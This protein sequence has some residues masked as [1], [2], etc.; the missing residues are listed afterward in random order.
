MVL[1]VGKEDP[2]GRC[3][4]MNGQVRAETPPGRW[5]ARSGVVAPLAEGCIPRPETGF[6]AAR[7]LARGVTVV[8]TQPTQP[9]EAAREPLG[10]TGKTQLA[11]AL[12]RT[13]WRSGEVD[14]LAWVPAGSRDAVMTG[15]GRALAAVGAPGAGAGLETAAAGFLAWAAQTS[16]PWLVVLD[17]LADPGDLDGLW[18]LGPAGM[19]LATTRLPAGAMAGP[20]RQILEV[21]PF[22]P[23]E[24]L[25]Y[26]AA[27]LSEER[28]LRAGALDLATDLGRL[29]LALAQAA[30]VIANCRI[31]CRAYRTH[32]ANRMQQMPVAGG[33]HAA[34]VAAAWSL[35]LNLAEQVTAPGTAGRA[36]ALLALLDP[37][38]VP[39]EVLASRAACDYICGRQ[40][41]GTPDDA[42]QVRSVVDTLSR[43]GVV[44]IDPDSAPRTVLMH[45]L[46]QATL[47]QVIPPELLQQATSAAADAV[48]QAWPQRGGEPLVEQALRDCTA[49]LHRAAPRLL[50]APEPHPVLV[51]AGQSLEQAGLASLAVC[52]W[53]SMITTTSQVLGPAHASIPLT[54]DHL[55]AACLAAGRTAEAISSCQQNLA[56][57]ER[58][59]GA[60]HPGTL[61]ARCSLARAFL[62]AGRQQEAI[63]LYEDTL[64][65]RERVLGPG[66]PATMATRDDLVAAYLS[67]GR[68]QPAIGLLQRSLS[69]QAR[70]LGPDH[71]GTLTVQ[72]AL[73]SALLS[74]GQPKQA[75]QLCERVLAGRERA[76]GAAH[77]DTMT[78]RASL[79]YA[80]RSAGRVNHA[81]PV[82]ERTLADRD[83][84]LGPD[85][86]DTLTSLANLASA[87]HS[88]HKLKQAV[89][90]YEAALTRHER[91]KGPDHPD[92]LAARGNLASAY[93]SAGR[94]SQAIS[95]HEQT[96][97]D[98]ERL[99]GP[100]HLSTL[101][102]RANLASAYHTVGR[103]IE[104]VTLFE[105]IL[106]DCERLLPPGH[107]MT[108]TIRENLQAAT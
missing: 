3:V 18:P 103:R 48:L 65:D 85:H 17:D 30:A 105:H 24:A 69:D 42:G 26:L 20:G 54:R 4:T 60:D 52:Y 87:Y 46:V 91:S 76:L 49:S 39:A 80:Y 63:Q 1:A 107:P 36:V 45:A 71:P 5:P 10:G 43:A 9:E 21:G 13:L 83:K 86:P 59:L 101:T 23:R 35:S 92:T 98:Y 70:V 100:D 66:H 50:W 28:D 72:A 41:T 55:A 19:V 108:Q 33:Q 51:R 44:T 78:A 64:A 67:A 14:L 61:T 82:Y 47:R 40:S 58:A 12:A 22:S 84:A 2:D 93:H 53:Q 7:G 8:L 27:R 99:M 79:A 104:A 38:G 6:S 32:L 16:Q 56:D 74:A 15:Y 106:A 25:S 81:L 37:A 96:L 102:A 77:P 34:T 31:D 89:P 90:L 68:A 11:V 62:R 95:L 57:R 88:A 97:R 29:P 73:A 94:L 75:T